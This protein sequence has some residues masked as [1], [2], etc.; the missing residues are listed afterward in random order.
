MPSGGGTLSNSVG[1]GVSG[2]GGV[3]VENGKW[4]KGRWIAPDAN[5]KET[6]MRVLQKIEVSL[7]AVLG[8]VFEF[9][10]IG[11][12]RRQIFSMTRSFIKA[13]LSASHFRILERQ[14][15]SFTDPKKLS[16]W[17]GELR[18]YIF[19]D[20]SEINAAPPSPD[21]QVL[22]KQCL[23]SI[24]ASFPSKALSLFGDTACE[25]AALKLHEF[26]QH[27]VFVKNLLFSITDELL[28]HLFPDSTTFKGK[29]ASG[30]TPAV[31]TPA[32][33]SAIEV[34][35][36]IAKEAVAASIDD[37]ATGLATPPL[38]PIIAATAPDKKL[39]VVI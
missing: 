4:K 13:F 18:M 25:N 10:G 11:M 21:I 38:S 1:S 15:L 28:L 8:E 20:P 23:E 2:A 12:V 24:L 6:K 37:D 17:I 5:S 9:D 19:P 3:L 35:T 26:L 16:G 34:A 33:P 27:E 14:F 31:P 32:S 22:R 36:T 30:G 7:F 39:K 29:K